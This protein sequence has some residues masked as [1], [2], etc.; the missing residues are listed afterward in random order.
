M[1]IERESENMS[2]RAIGSQMTGSSS[3]SFKPSVSLQHTPTSGPTPRN[4]A[5]PST[6]VSSAPKKELKLTVI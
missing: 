3:T 5:P 4:I 1:H 2:R 6:N